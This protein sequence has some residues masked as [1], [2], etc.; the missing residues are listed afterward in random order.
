VMAMLLVCTP[1]E[2]DQRL[3]AEGTLKK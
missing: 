2:E 3:W 1:Q